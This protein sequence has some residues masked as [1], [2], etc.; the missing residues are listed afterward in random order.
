MDIQARY[1]LNETKYI[2]FGFLILW[3][4]SKQSPREALKWFFIQNNPMKTM[5]LKIY[6]IMYYIYNNA[7]NTQTVY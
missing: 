4:T 2:T 6:E 1:P 7:N 5:T 3:K